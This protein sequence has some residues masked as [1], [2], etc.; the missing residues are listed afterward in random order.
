M[1]RQAAPTTAGGALVVGG[2][3]VSIAVARS[4]GR[5][6]IPVWLLASHP[7]PRLSRY[8]QRSFPWP[9][10]EHPD[11]LASIIDVA[12]RHGLNGWVLFATG[13]EDMRLIAQNHALLASHF[14]VATTNWDTTQWVY[15]KRLTYRRAASL[16]IECPRSFQACDLETL[17]QSQIQFP[18]V[19]KPACRDA[20]NDFTRAKAWKADDRDALVSLYRRAA[21]LVG[22]D[23]VIVQ[24]WIPGNG[25][26]QFSYAGLWDRGKPVAS[27]V[28]R[29]ARQYPVDFGRSSTFV[30]TVEQEQVKALACRF[31]E[32]LGYSGVVEIEFKYDRRDRRYK[33][34]D[35]NGRF[36]TWNGLGQ[37]A[38]VDI[39]YLA[40][41]QALGRDVACGPAKAGVAW[42]YASRDIRAAFAEISR[43]VLSAG[44]YLAGFRRELVFASFAVDDPLPAI[45]ELP[46]LAWNRLT[47]RHDGRSGLR[48]TKKSTD[49]LAAAG[50]P[51]PNVGPKIAADL[52]ADL[53]ASIHAD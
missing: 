17:G 45:A 9:G 26:A 38:G 3:H 37:R 6:G 20:I 43:G 16:G 11:G 5:R 33:L 27:L 47:K 34:L 50:G 23:A 24:E 53:R 40:W 52:R 41:R 30:E 22:S 28:A 18:V 13:D 36:W 21:S 35:V 10:A 14:R 15:D 1:T 2:A 7:L 8:V 25:E 48:G 4:L 32:S 12:V 31:L 29:R 46:L 19:L 44:D 49:D 39:P 51:P 42:M